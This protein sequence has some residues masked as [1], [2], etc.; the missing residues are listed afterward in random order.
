MARRRKRDDYAGQIV[1]TLRR[2]YGPTHPRAKIDAYRYNPGSIR[3]R[4]IDPDFEDKDPVDRD[5]EIR[6][7]LRK[8]LPEEVRGDINLLLLFTPEESEHSIINL[9]F[10]EPT[11]SRL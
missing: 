4:V 7:I 3:V 1:E 6:A 10:E 9:E 8:H 2:E 11:P 5:K